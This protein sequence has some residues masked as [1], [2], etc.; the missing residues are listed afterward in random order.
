MDFRV[1][2][3][4]KYDESNTGESMTLNTKFKEGA[5]YKRFIKAKGE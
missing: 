4:S 5:Y 3:L 1:L 2:P